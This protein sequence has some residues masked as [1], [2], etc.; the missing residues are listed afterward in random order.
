[1]VPILL[2]PLRERADDIPALAQH[3]LQLAAAEGLPRRFLASDAATLLA[4]QPWRGNVREL[5]NF[6]YRLALLARED[7]V[8]AAS[9]QALLVPARG[10]SGEVAAAEGGA[11]EG[12]VWTWLAHNRPP[13]G[14]IYDQ[15]LAAFERPLFIAVMRDTGGNQV[16]AAGRL[17]INRNTLRK[18]LH[19]LGIGPADWQQGA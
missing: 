13:P 17:G 1:V 15:A 14:E 16:Q 4:Q 9:V 10:P 8:D 6:I 3:F 12:A 18:R 7:Q 19:D 2:P 5:R 11:L